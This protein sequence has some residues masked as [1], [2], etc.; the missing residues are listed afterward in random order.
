MS[1]K[2][3][4]LCFYSS[5]LVY[6][7]QKEPSKKRFPDIWEVGWKCTKFL[8][9]YLK[10]QVSFYLNFVSLSWEIT[11]LY[12]FSWD[13]IWFG[14]KP[15]RVQNFRL[16]TALV[17]FH[18]SCTLIVSFWWKYIKFQL[19]KCGGVMSHDTE[20]W[21]KIWRKTDLLFQKWQE[22]V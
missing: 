4:Q 20:E 6:F 11:L 22:F 17:K 10:P 9:S 2:I 8:M 12:L 21:Y 14:Q 18:Q 16:S 19:K 3:T 7:W 15:I 1:W 5:N 13:F